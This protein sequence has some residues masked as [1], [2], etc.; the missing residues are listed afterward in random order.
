MNC[1]IDFLIERIELDSRERPLRFL[2][3]EMNFSLIYRIIV[4]LLSLTQYY[5]LNYLKR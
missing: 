5:F 2:I 3:V 1:A 4:S